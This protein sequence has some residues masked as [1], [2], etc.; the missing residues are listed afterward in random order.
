MV[1]PRPSDDWGCLKSVNVISIPIYRERNLSFCLD[2]LV[3]EFTSPKGGSADRERMPRAI[4]SPKI[5]TYPNRI[6][7]LLIFKPECKEEIQNGKDFDN[8]CP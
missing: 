4:L 7:K 3:A 6:A 5:P 8:T 1:L 2:F